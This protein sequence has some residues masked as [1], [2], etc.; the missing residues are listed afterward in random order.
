MI[1]TISSN[2][3]EGITNCWRKRRTQRRE[4]NVERER[5]QKL[6]NERIKQKKKK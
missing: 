3:L 5:K 4:S 2:Y 6:K 1:W